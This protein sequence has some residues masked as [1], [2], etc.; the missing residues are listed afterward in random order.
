MLIAPVVLKCI[1]NMGGCPTDSPDSTR[2]HHQLTK[3]FAKKQHELV[4][5]MVFQLEANEELF[6]KTKDSS[7]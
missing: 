1:D 6:S 5:K 2:M 4:K 7:L 3:A